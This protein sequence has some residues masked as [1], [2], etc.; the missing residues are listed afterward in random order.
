MDRA[1]LNY[2][3]GRATGFERMVEY[4]TEGLA[5]VVEMEHFEAKM[6]GS[7]E[8]SP[9]TL[10]VTTILRPEDGTWEIVHRHADPIAAAR[11]AESVIGGDGHQR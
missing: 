3:D 2:R 6:A 9:V 7:Q 4:A 8:F 10:R 1:A 5:Y 11:S